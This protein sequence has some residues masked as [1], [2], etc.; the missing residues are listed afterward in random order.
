VTDASSVVTPS[1]P[2]SCNDRAPERT[3]LVE[4]VG[5]PAYVAQCWPTL[6][7]C[8]HSN[9][10]Q[11]TGVISD[12]QK[13]ASRT[14]QLAASDVFALRQL[15]EQGVQSFDRVVDLRLSRS[16][17]RR[18]LAAVPVHPERDEDS[19]SAR[20]RPT[21]RRHFKIRRERSVAFC[22]HNAI[23]VDR[24]RLPW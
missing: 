16:E 21:R 22:R 13:S 7:I 24:S 1:P 17:A 20:S 6:P 4:N 5:V 2:S 8:P 18:D 15:R 10:Q 11:K 23:S 12:S 19:A 9:P 3:V 14:E